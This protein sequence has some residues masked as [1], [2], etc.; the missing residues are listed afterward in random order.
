MAARREEPSTGEAADLVVRTI[1]DHADSMLRVARKYS[2]CADDAH[3]RLPARDGDL[4]AAGRDAWTRRRRAAWLRTVVK[5]EAIA[6]RCGAPCRCSARTT[7]TPSRARRS[8]S[9]RSRGAGAELRHGLPLGRGAAAAQAP[10]GARAV[11][12]GGRPQLHAD[13]REHRVDV[14]EG[15]PLHRRG[16]QELPG[17]LRR[18]R[19]RARSASAG[20]RWSRRSSTARPPRA[21][22]REA[23]PH[24]RNCL[25]CRAVMRDADAQR[26]SFAALFPVG[27]AA[28]AARRRTSGPEAGGF[29][30]RLY[31]A[32]ASA[33]HERA[34][35][36]MVKF[37]AVLDL[38]S[39]GKVAA[40]AASAAAVAGGGAAVVD[41]A[42]GSRDARPR[43]AVV[44]RATAGSRP[45]G[46]GGRAQAGRREAGAAPKR[47]TASRRQTVTREF[48]SSGR[49]SRR[50]EREFGG[51]TTSSGRRRG[52]S[53]RRRPRRRRRRRRCR[54]R[55][56]GRARSS[57][58]SA[59]ANVAACKPTSSVRS[60]ARRT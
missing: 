35:A 42:T 10:G 18:D 57:P 32:L 58:S 23:R 24:L 28:G 31:D 55:R 29:L 60:R 41:K 51:R 6:V 14:H 5:H 43:Q 33:L 45:R 1:R 59:A 25:A 34:T 3:G 39:T 16:P 52:S 37:Q 21:Q 47:R 53:G 36:S 19:V 12:E 50:V 17:P 30:A 8:T 44:H 54:R 13:R 49:A 48:G 9:R 15:Q 11:A 22:M 20:R 46:P 56:R 40:V 7:P 2:I 4:H 26:A 27:A 38:A